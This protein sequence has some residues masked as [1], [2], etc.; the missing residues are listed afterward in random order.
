MMRGW[1][2]AVASLLVSGTLAVGCKKS[3]KPPADAPPPPVDA[4]ALTVDAASAD[5]DPEALTPPVP[6][7]K[8]GVQVLGVEYEGHEAKL[9]P[10]IKGDG[11]QVAALSIGD[12]GGRGYLDLALQIVDGKTG[13]LV[14]ELTLVEPDETTAAQREDGSFE[15]ALLD[16]VKRR[17]A[18]ANARF[19]TGDWRALASHAADPADAEAPIVAAGITWSLESGLHLVGK[20][21]GKVVFDR[22]YTQLTGKKA[23][24]GLDE[25]DMCPDIVVLSALHVDEPTGRALV[26]FGRQSGHNCGAPGDDLAV[27]A[28]PR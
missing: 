27:I 9:L 5:G 2:V 3:A 14:E 24:R 7:G 28:L 12:D 11:S 8:P 17:V 13:K 18:D 20:R 25:E 6:A 21:A 10:A 4:P 19:A 16:A 1:F 15:P 23:P 22:T 26:A